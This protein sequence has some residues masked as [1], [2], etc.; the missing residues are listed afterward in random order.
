MWPCGGVRVAQAVL[1]D[2]VGQTAAAAFAFS[3]EKLQ[4]QEKIKSLGDGTTVV[5]KRTTF[6]EDAGGDVDK[7]G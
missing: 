3:A 1:A 7:V 2:V 6:L 4:L 5:Q